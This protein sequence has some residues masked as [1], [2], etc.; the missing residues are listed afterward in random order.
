MS[1]LYRQMCK[2]AAARVCLSNS[3]GNGALLAQQRA[4]LTQLHC[5]PTAATRSA[6]GVAAV[7]S[8]ASGKRVATL[9]VPTLVAQ[10]ASAPSTTLFCRSASTLPPFTLHLPAES[11]KAN[12]SFAL[13]P[14]RYLSSANTESTKKMAK[15]Q[16]FFDMTADNQPLGRIV[17]EVSH[18]YRLVQ[19]FLLILLF[20]S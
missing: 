12:R 13:P 3:N 4:H 11:V 15:P 7:L 1:V 16:V 2:S 18:L 5:L 10:R 14:L 8:K 6:C 17:I 9:T 20:S 19:F